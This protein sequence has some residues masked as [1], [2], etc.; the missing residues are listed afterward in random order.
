MTVSVEFLV[1][2]PLVSQ[3][4]LSDGAAVYP[5]DAVPAGYVAA[6][7]Y[8]SPYGGW[9][10]GWSESYAKSRKEKGRKE[11]APATS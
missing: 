7:Y 11:K 5:R 8:P 2:S 3:V 10:S 6:P 9:V 1:I 4:S